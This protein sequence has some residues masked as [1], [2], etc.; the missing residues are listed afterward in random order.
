MSEDPSI[1]TTFL[2]EAR[3]PLEAPI[4]SGISPEGQ[5]LVFVVKEGVVRGP[6]LNGKV[7]AA[8]GADWARLRPDG[9]GALDVRINI[10]TGDGAVLYCEWLGIMRFPPEDAEYALD[11][12][13][14]DDPDGA[15]RYYFRSSP[16]FETGD[17]RYAWLNTT[18]CVCKSRTGDGGVIHQ[19]FAV[20]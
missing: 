7:I 4:D 5:R 9:S 16:R 14:P 18:V 17:E 10:E 20:N 19:I 11:F 1:D 8:S 12:S 2:C 3:V 6:K 15:S 13:K